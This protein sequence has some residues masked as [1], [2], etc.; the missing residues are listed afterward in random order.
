MR[1]LRNRH[2]RGGSK[3]GAALTQWEMHFGPNMTPMVD[4]VMV[5]LI[6]FM[7]GTAIMAPEM[8]LTAGLAVEPGDENLPGPI[9]EDPFELPP[10]RFTLRLR[11]AGGQTVIDG[12]GLESGAIE[13]LEGRLASV[14]G[15]GG[16]GSEVA[17]LIQPSVDVPFADVVAVQDQVVGAGIERVG[18]LES[19]GE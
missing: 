11:R 19:G 2:K 8:F 17:I 12:L 4:V 1:E 14:S 9:V 7:A 6:F 18:L 16:D 5:I 15:D 3:K 10:A 13:D